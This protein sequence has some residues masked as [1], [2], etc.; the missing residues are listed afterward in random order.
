MKSC[1]QYRILHDAAISLQRDATFAVVASYGKPIDHPLAL[2]LAYQGETVGQLLLAPR[3]PGDTFTTVDRRLLDELA[4]HAGLAVHAVQLTADL[5]RS[6]ERLTRS[7]GMWVARG[8]S[9]RF[10]VYEKVFER[11]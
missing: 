9:L 8:G 1:C 4:R 7:P 10:R 11:E 2:L 5:Q 3:A 6:R